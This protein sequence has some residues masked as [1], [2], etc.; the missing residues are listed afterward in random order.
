[1]RQGCDRRPS[2]ARDHSLEATTTTRT[3][4]TAPE[5]LITIGGSFFIGV[6]AISAAF[7]PEIRWLHAAQAAMYVAAIVLSIRRRPWGYFIGA[8]V[9]GFWNWLAM[10]GSPLFAEF[11]AQPARPDLVLQTLAWFANLA[12][13]V[14]SVLGYRRL[15][16]KSPRDGGSFALAFLA[17]TAFLVGSTYLLA[18]TYVSHLSGVLHPHWPWTR[19]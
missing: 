2:F 8:S 19:S 18:P 3:R 14:G 10:F 9:A 6:L 4:F 5:W 13:V 12:V 17:T 15:A 16:V 1:M 11:I 7:L